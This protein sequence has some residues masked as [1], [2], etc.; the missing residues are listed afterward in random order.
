VTPAGEILRDEIHRHGPIP[1]S[2][3]MEVALYH[4]ECGYYRR[5]RRD[6]FGK[7][8]DFFTASQFQPV[9]GRL[10]ASTVRRWRDEMS[11]PDGFRV[12]ELGAGRGEMEPALTEFGYTAVDIDRGELPH[13][14][15]GVVFA[16]EF[17]DALPVDVLCR[18]DGVFHF[19]KVDCRGDLFQW[20]A[21]EPAAGESLNYARLHAAAFDAVEHSGDLWLE[22]PV[23][24]SF[25]LAGIARAL[26]SGSLLLIDYGFTRREAL[27]FPAGTLMSYRR[28]RAID[29]VLRDPGQQDIT[30]HVPFTWIE[31]RAAALGLRRVRFESMASFLLAAGEP[32]QFASALA[33][34]SEAE[35]MRLR[36][37]LKT[38]LFGMGESFFA[39][40]LRAGG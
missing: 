40:V 5:E 15:N 37:Q 18:R 33:A 2:R 25:W 6:P 39:L 27:H 1:F 14:F 16:N 22:I 28:H 19:M 8:G 24:A 10:I 23:G 11:S 3:F 36:L 38:L 20:S 13:D 12:V 31:E 4:P 30:A 34:D 35:S 29:D 26:R 7:E 9:F 17:F 21:A 32:D